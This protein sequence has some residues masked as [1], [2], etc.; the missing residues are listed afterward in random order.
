MSLLFDQLL[1]HQIYLEGL[2][3][4]ELT[5]INRKYLTALEKIIK[6]EL[7]KLPFNRVDALTKTG[8][9]AVITR[10]QRAQK[11]ALKEWRADL[12]TSLREYAKTDSTIAA[13]VM[14]QHGKIKKPAIQELWA[15]VAKT[16]VKGSNTPVRQ[17]LDKMS[18]QQMKAIDTTIRQAFDAGETIDDVYGAIRGTKETGYS[19][20]LLRKYRDDLRANGK[21]IFQH[22]KG[23]VH[24][25]V[26]SG[27]FSR[28]RWVSVIDS[29]TSSICRGR[30]GKVYTYGDGPLPPAHF[31]CRSSVVPI[32][33]NVDEPSDLDP[34]FF[35]WVQKQPEEF[36][37]DIFPANQAEKLIKGTAKR[38]DFPRFEGIGSLTMSEFKSK[39]E[40]IQ[41]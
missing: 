41:L 17:M 22:V 20:G 39:A 4:G 13:S 28:Y 16:N 38:D 9:R 32:A 35:E 18:A 1:R 25:A 12:M 11:A 40:I 34:P 21:T 37:R 3:E 29:A 24:S 15:E 36:I 26:A 7:G 23:R 10:I 6:R 31:N 2:K 5:R 19:D 27:T 14:R 30:N 8:R 33:D